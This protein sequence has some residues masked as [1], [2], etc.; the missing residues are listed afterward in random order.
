MYP[1]SALN[2]R[3]EF[4]GLSQPSIAW[5]EIGKRGAKKKVKLMV[6]IAKVLIFTFPPD[7]SK[8]VTR[9]TNS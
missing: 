5:A 3:Q 8:Q 6:E 4:E 2:P 9:I 1:S 7:A